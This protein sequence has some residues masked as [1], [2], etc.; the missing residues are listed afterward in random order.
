MT[1]EIYVEIEGASL[2]LA[3]ALRTDPSTARAVIAK[4]VTDGAHY[5]H[6]I[7]FNAARKA[8]NLTGADLGLALGFSATQTDPEKRRA[9]AGR[10]IR[11]YEAKGAPTVAA[12]AL[13]WMAFSGGVLRPQPQDK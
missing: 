12:H 3:D 9:N 4:A 10:T 7:I 13:R 2:P 5:E 1:N 6:P 8:L 11:D